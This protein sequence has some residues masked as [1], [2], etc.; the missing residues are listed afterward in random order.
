MANISKKQDISNKSDRAS[1]AAN[2]VVYSFK[3][4]KNKEILVDEDWS[5]TEE[6]FVTVVSQKVACYV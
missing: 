2:K 3:K 1:D 6:H 4:E 5:E